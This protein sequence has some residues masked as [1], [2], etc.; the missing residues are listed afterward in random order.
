MKRILSILLAAMMVVSLAVMLVP[1]SAADAAE[2]P[3]DYSFKFED[4]D[5]RNQTADQVF[6]LAAK[7][8]IEGDI[9]IDGVVDTLYG[10][11]YTLKKTVGTAASNGPATMKAY[12]AVKAGTLY[13][14]IDTGLD[15]KCQIR[16]MPGLWADE[17]SGSGYSRAQFTQKPDGSIAEKDSLTAVKNV[18]INNASSKSQYCWVDDFLVDFDGDGN[19]NNNVVWNEGV[20]EMAIDIGGIYNIF[21]SL[22]PDFSWD[23]PCM[24]LSVYLLKT[25]GTPVDNSHALYGVSPQECKD[26]GEN[27]KLKIG[28]T[29]VGDFIGYTIILPE[30]SLEY[31]KENYRGTVGEL[32]TDWRNA[33]EGQLAV[34]EDYADRA[35]VVD[36]IVD[37]NE[38]TTA[39]D[40]TEAIKANYAVNGGYFY[41][42]FTYAEETFSDLLFEPFLAVNAS[43]NFTL[44]KT[45]ATLKTDGSFVANDGA[46]VRAG[47]IETFVD[48]FFGSSNA[49]VTCAVVAAGA[50]HNEG[51]T[52]YEVK[53]DLVKLIEVFKDL[54]WDAAEGNCIKFNLAPGADAANAVSYTLTSAQSNGVAYHAGSRTGKTQ[55]TLLYVLPTVALP[56]DCTFDLTP[57]YH[58]H[59]SDTKV[60]VKEATHLEDGLVTFTCDECGEAIEQVLPRLLA[61]EFAPAEKYSADF[62]KVVCPCGQ[63]EY[64]VHNWDAGKVVIAATETETGKMLYTCADCGETYEEIIPVIVPE[65]TQPP[66]TEPVTPPVTEPVTPPTTEAPTTEAPTTEAPTTEA[67]TTAAPTTVTPTTAAEEKGCNNTIA[68][69]A[70]AIVPMLGAAVVFGKKRED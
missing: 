35:P 54:G 57:V 33:I 22:M 8:E 65:A 68:L 26:K 30:T 23:N 11:A 10:D 52:T 61:H 43:G 9:V 50:S 18:H 24:A 12:L 7:G 19:R 63:V 6:D 59:T 47:V 16:V 70:L 5:A 48:K 14:A 58:E 34:V 53:V 21:A 4:V 2:V 1:V 37:A 40:V 45:S 17:T 38:Y 64:V 56:D 55:Q 25:A 67:P 66:V 62:H 3:N 36:G 32:G 28:N 20:Y 15:A 41:A 51:V 39:H 60:V 31:V 13:I 49:K 42:S 27:N 44:S 46:G 69:S 29:E